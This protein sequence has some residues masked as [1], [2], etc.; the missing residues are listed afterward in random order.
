MAVCEVGAALVRHESG[1][2]SR[3]ER[4]RV[5]GQ[6]VMRHKDGALAADGD[7]AGVARQ[8]IQDPRGH[9]H[10]V[11]AAGF[12]VGVLEMDKLLVENFDVPRE[13]AGR[14]QA[15]LADGLLRGRD[16]ERVFQ[17]HQVG[18]EDAGQLVVK[19]PGEVVAQAAHLIAAGGH[20]ARKLF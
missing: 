19:V 16:D 10:Q 4:G 6:H 9:V 13:G 2:F 17:H 20:G 18:V 7:V 12:E 3:V 5:R 15:A 8:I 11:R 1:D 14:V